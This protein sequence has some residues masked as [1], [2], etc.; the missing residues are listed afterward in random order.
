MRQTKQ[1][2]EI[3]FDFEEF[4]QSRLSLSETEPVYCP[5]YQ[6]DQCRNPHCKY[7]HTKLAN[8]VVCKHWLRGLCK[9]NERCDFLHEYNLRKMPECFFFNVYGVCNN[10]ECLFLHVN[11]EAAVRECVWYRRGFCKNGAGCKNKHIRAKLC[12]DYFAGFCKS[13][14]DCRLGHPRFEIKFT[15]ITDEDVLN[16]PRRR[17]VA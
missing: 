11:P 4:I 13:G 1:T 14:A 9:K 6:R 7:I 8:S 12:W 10:S 2:A 3:H 5:L 15:E 17:R 16:R